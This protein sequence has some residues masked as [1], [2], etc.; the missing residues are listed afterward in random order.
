VHV[1]GLESRGL[2]RA[3][4]D[5]P[6]MVEVRRLEHEVVRT[7][8]DRLD[9]VLDRAV[10]REHDHGQQRIGLAQ[11]LQHLEAIVLAQLEVEHD[12]VHVV[13]T[14]GV[15]RLTAVRGLER[16]ESLAARPLPDA[17]PQGPLVVNDE[18]R[19]PG[20]RL[21]RAVAFRH[22]VSPTGS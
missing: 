6:E 2:D 12:H 4:H 13:L 18:Q 5:H 15:E 22:S 20:R 21:R 9:R 16:R 10:P 8:V 11:F 3:I 14:H 1:L 7:E 17:E 19:S